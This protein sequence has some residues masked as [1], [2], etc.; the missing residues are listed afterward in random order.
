MIIVGRRLL[1]AGQKM[2]MFHAMDFAGTHIFLP[3]P[4]KQPDHEIDEILINLFWMPDTELEQNYGN[5]AMQNRP[6]HESY[7]SWGDRGSQVYIA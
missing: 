4:N 3:Y 2:I 5:P 1:S 6:M 7:I